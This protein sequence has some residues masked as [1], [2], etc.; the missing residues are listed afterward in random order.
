MPVVNFTHGGGGR[1][2]QRGFCRHGRDKAYLMLRQDDGDGLSS[3]A[4][5]R[6][7]PGAPDNGRIHP[8]FTIPEYVET[9]REAIMA[10]SGICFLGAAAAEKHPSRKTSATPWRKGYR[11]LLVGN[12]ISLFPSTVLLRGEADIERAGRLPGTLRDRLNDYDSAHPRR[13]VLP[14]AGQHRRPAWAAPR[15]RLIDNAGRAGVIQRLSLDFILY[16]ISGETPC[17]G[18]ILP[19]REGVMQR[20]IIVTNGSFASVTTAN[21]ILQAILRLRGRG[22]LPRAAHH[23][24]CLLP[25][26]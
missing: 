5:G 12:D 8:V 9:V 18:Y 2:P 20:C 26:Q 1:A 22:Q 15:R 10:Q 19:I 25:R 4:E 23:E 6:R 11:V 16:D 7:G 13:R 17:T 14:G 3:S 21:S 24:Q